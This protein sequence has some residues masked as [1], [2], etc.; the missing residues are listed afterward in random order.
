MIFI[1]SLFLIFPFFVII[2]SLI[3][4]LLWEFFHHYLYYCSDYILPIPPFVHD[5]SGDYFVN[6]SLTYLLFYFSLFLI[7]FASA[8]LSYK[9]YKS[10]K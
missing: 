4:I 8:F 1:G 7:I 5:H 10:T 6:Q 2:F 9:F 3:F